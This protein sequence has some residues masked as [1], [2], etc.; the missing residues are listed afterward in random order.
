MDLF[1]ITLGIQEQAP[2]TLNN[3]ETTIS[4]SFSMHG[5]A[6][7][8]LVQYIRIEHKGHLANIIF[9]CGE[10]KNATGS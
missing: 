8:S 3:L 7:V 9:V 10:T 2:K 1:T 5:G 6:A 4:N